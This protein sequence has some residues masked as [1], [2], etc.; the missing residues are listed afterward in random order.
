MHFLFNAFLNECRSIL[1]T[2][3]NLKSK[4]LELALTQAR[5]SH[6]TA[7]WTPAFTVTFG[8]LGHGFACPLEKPEQGKITKQIY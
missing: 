1:R 2:F 5:L 8:S 7:L 4:A 6:L 3:A